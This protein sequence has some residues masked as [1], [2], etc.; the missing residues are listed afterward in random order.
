MVTFRR[1]TFTVPETLLDPTLILSPHVFLL[2]VLFRHEAFGA[3]FLT[4]ASHLQRLYIPPGER[5]LPLPIRQDLDNVP[6]FR[7]AFKTPK[8]FEMS[9]TDSIT[10]NMMSGWIKKVGQLLGRLYTTI[11]YNLRYNAGNELDGSCK[12]QTLFG[13]F[14]CLSLNSLRQ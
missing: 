4:S 7:R 5:E 9:L 10:Y 12:S 3:D 6:L 13:F 2:G 8:G 11:C 1:K 14:L